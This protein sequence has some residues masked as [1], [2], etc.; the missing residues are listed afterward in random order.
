MSKDEE[1]RAAIISAQAERELAANPT[2]VVR[3][4]PRP[5]W[6]A[7]PSVPPNRRQAN[8]GPKPNGPR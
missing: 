5:N 1:R 3:K 7:S 6:A 2:G 4:K 8:R